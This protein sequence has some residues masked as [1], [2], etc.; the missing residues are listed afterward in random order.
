MI[1]FGRPILH[2]GDLCPDDIEPLR[3]RFI[4]DDRDSRTTPSLTFYAYTI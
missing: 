2:I 1:E 3:N 4:K